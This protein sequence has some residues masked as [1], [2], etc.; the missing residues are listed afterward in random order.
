MYSHMSVYSLLEDHGTK[1]IIKLVL[2]KLFHVFSF[3]NIILMFL[4]FKAGVICACVLS[5]GVCFVCMC[6]SHR[7]ALGWVKGHSQAS[8]LSKLDRPMAKACSAHM[9]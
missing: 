4:H 3:Q 5:A 1:T 6:V 7:E 9:G 2:F 8:L